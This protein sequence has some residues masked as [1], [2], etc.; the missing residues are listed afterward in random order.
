MATTPISAKKKHMATTS[1]SA[2]AQALVD[3]I[4]KLKLVATPVLEGKA[5]DAA[6]TFAGIA[7]DL[8]TEPRMP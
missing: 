1:I 5:K 8:A 7:K 3:A 2:D 6:D 4:A